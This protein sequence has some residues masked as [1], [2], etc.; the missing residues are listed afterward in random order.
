[1]SNRYYVKGNEAE[2]E[3]LSEKGGKDVYM[4]VGLQLDNALGTD[5]YK[6]L[7]LVPSGG[8]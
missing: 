3:R 7:Q 8:V 6:Q 1:M 4:C 2:A 5:F